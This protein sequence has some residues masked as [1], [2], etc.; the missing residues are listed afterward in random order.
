MIYSL[1]GKISF[2]KQG[3]VVVDVG[4][5]GFKVSCPQRIIS[6]LKE[7]DQ[8]RLFTHFYL[9]E[10]KVDLYGFLDQEELSVFDFLNLVNGVGPKSAMA[11]MNASGPK[12]I[13][14]AIRSGRAD[15]LAQSVGIGKKLA[16]RIVLELKSRVGVSGDSADVIGMESNNEVVD[17]LLGLGYR[18][19]QVRLAVSKLDTSLKI[20]DKVKEALKILSGKAK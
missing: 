14:A 20:E 16:D 1:A 19:D 11:I 12:D 4:G 10:D 7:G 3:F 6:Q 17:I 18:R 9:K 15:L 5:I 8:V 2:I 13:L